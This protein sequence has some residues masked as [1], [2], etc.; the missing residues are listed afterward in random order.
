MLIIFVI[1]ILVFLI[2]FA[3][4]VLYDTECT[5]KMLKESD[6]LHDEVASSYKKLID[7]YEGYCNALLEK[8]E[9]LESEVQK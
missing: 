4:G 6:E 2:G 7:A 3:F 9:F 5:L 8:I 1:I